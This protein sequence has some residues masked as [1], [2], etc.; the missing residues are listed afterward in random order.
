MR[1][2]RRYV[3]RRWCE[4]CQ[5]VTDSVICDGEE[6][7]ANEMRAGYFCTQALGPDGDHIATGLTAEVSRW[8]P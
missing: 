4:T 2:L 8:T 5:Q 7:C 6:V 1:R 3:I